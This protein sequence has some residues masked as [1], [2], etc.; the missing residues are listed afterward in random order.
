MRRQW[1][2]VPHLLLVM[3][4]C[5]QVSAATGWP[6]SR[7]PQTRERTRSLSSRKN[8]QHPCWLDRFQGRPRNLWRWWQNHSQE[9]L[10]TPGGLLESRKIRGDYYPQQG[11]QGRLVQLE[12]SPSRQSEGLK[13]V[14]KPE[15]CVHLDSVLQLTGLSKVCGHQIMPG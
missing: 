6:E 8:S 7:T 10:Q 1:L 3:P 9:P 4:L 13:Q 2:L 12:L 5:W 11:G 14:I 15:V